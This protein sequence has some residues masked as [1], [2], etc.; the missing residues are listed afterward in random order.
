[1][2]ILAKSMHES[3]PRI[4]FQR[5]TSVPPKGFDSGSHPLSLTLRFLGEREPLFWS[6]SLHAVN[7][8]RS[9][10]AAAASSLLVFRHDG[11]DSL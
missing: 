11:S 9:F 6:R 4:Y 2:A 5:M 8:E 7:T 3:L 10:L 1:M